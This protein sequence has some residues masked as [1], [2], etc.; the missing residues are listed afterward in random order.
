MNSEETFLS[1]V[2]ETFKSIDGLK[3][4]SD[5]VT[6]ET[7]SG[8]KFLM[9]HYQDCCESVR[10]VDCEGDDAACLVG[11]PVLSA[12]RVSNADGPTPEHPDSC[13]WTFYKLSTAKG[14]V[15]LRWLGESNGYYGE[16]V[17]FTEQKP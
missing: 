15:T 4:D 8:R 13:T 12:E 16:D 17:D 5:A 7:E 6:F 2:G 3:N 1:L 14:S 9:C 11:S 10:L